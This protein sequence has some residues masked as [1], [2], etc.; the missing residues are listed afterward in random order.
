MLTVHNSNVHGYAELEILLRSPRA[1][2]AR[3]GYD[4]L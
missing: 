1:L 3:I 4:V 2:N